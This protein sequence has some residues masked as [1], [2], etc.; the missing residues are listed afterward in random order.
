MSIRNNETSSGDN[1]TKPKVLLIQ[2]SIKNYRVPV[3]NQLA[4][5]VDLTVIYDNGNVPAGC[6]FDVIKV[7]LLRLKHFRKIHLCN[8]WSLIKKYDVVIMMLDPS[9][10]STHLLAHCHS[11]TPIVYWGIGVAASRS[12]RYDSCQK[13]TK[14]LYKLI[15]KSSASIFYCDYP[16]KKYSQMGISQQKLFAAN[17]TVQVYPVVSQEKKN[18]LFFGSLYKEKR[19]FELLEAYR[20]VYFQNS[21]IPDL[22][23]IGGGEEYDAIKVWIHSNRLDK[24]IT[25]TGAIY[26]DLVLSKFFATAI[27]CISPDQAGLSVLK[28]FGYGVPFVT[29]KDAITGGERF[30]ITPDVTG[31]LIDD[32][33]ELQKIILDS[34]IHKEKYLR[35]GDNAKAFYQENRTVD[36]MV[37]GFMDAI[38]YC[39]KQN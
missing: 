15:K 9:Y 26:D 31:L 27:M 12:L 33:E 19:I 29:H 10:F 36:K 37:H 39:L 28:S 25:L 24:K 5:H 6:N 22:T 11:V 21:Q 3:F 23:I 34:V 14:V 35:M 2:S 4:K 38:D 13:T 1:I 8:I 18:I 17:N 16:I 32:F 7:N 30:N 20:T